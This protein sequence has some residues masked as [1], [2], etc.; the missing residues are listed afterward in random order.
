MHHRS[1]RRAAALA[2]AAALAVAGIASADTVRADGDAVTPGSQVMVDLGEVAP[3]TQL[4]IPVSFELVCGSETHLDPGQSVSLTLSASSA[5]PGGQINAV[6]PGSVGPAPDGWTPD[7]QGCPF[8]APTLTTGTASLVT[9]TAP[10][11]I[12]VG[13][14]YTIGYARSVSPAGADDANALRSTTS[15]SF[16]LA[17]VANVAPVLTV[18]ADLTAEGNATGGWTAAYPGVSAT[19]AEDDPDPVPAC[20]PAAEEVLPLGTTTVSCSVTDS[21]GRSDAGSFAVTVVDTTAPSIAVGDDQTVTTDDP[22]GTVL[23]FDPPVVADVVD[24]APVVTCDPPAGAAIPVGTTTVTCTAT[25][26]SGNAAAASFAVSVAYVP[27]HVASG[28]WGEPVGQ[29][30]TVFVANRGRTLPLKVV[31]AVDGVARSTGDAILTVT[32]CGGGAAVVRTLTFGGGRWDAALDTS[33]LTGSCHVVTASL[34]GL[35]A[36]SFRLELSGA[37]A[38]AESAKAS[39]RARAR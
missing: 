4:T 29:G 10:A 3:S 18:P 27:S 21:G 5:A 39:A 17:V 16:R 30:T 14:V 26:A 38:A 13:Y 37:E 33:D 25:D 12:N 2:L 1:L 24:P 8:P 34:D 22:A 9:I 19:D 7:G 36:T 28:T 20:S 15:V 11:A 35:D 23:A 6:T 32:P 31:L